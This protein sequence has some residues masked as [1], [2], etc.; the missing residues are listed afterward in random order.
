MIAN[1]KK[2]IIGFDICEVSPGENDEWDANVGA[3]VL[4]KT[5]IYTHL[6]SQKNN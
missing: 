6:N 3:R 5:C 2:R 1:S 4:Y